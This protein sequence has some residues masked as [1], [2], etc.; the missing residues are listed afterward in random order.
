MQMSLSDSGIGHDAGWV[1][2]TYR[3]GSPAHVSRGKVEWPWQRCPQMLWLNK[4]CVNSVSRI[5]AELRG[6]EGREA[7]WA[8]QAPRFFPP[9]GGLAQAVALICVVE[10]GA[11]ACPWPSRA[12]LFLTLSTILYYLP[13]PVFW[14][15]YHNIELLMP[16]SRSLRCWHYP[17]YSSVFYLPHYF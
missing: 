5:S 10:A 1:T 7:L 13:K 9:S 12:S 14:A 8:H 4:I 6:Q 11:Q 17:P 15:T 16:S 3:G 2:H